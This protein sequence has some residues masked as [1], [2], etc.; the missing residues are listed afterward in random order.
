MGFLSTG[1]PAKKEVWG[2]GICVKRVN[3]NVCSRSSDPW[4]CVKTRARTKLMTTSSARPTPRREK[5]KTH[6]VLRAALLTVLMTVLGYWWNHE[7]EKS[8]L[9]V[10][11]SESRVVFGQK[12]ILYTSFSCFSCVV[13]TLAREVLSQVK[14]GLFEIKTTKSMVFCPMSVMLLMMLKFNMW[15]WYNVENAD[16]VIGMFL[17]QIWA[18]GACHPSSLSPRHIYIVCYQSKSIRAWKK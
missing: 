12:N 11:F 5:S 9:H 3:V 13:L 1:Q 8:K 7:G 17:V 4:R 14:H 15:F 16:H 18:F 6:L 2:G 10:V